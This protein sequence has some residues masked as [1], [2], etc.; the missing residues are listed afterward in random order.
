MTDS[1]RKGIGMFTYVCSVKT[2][3]IYQYVNINHFNNGFAKNLIFFYFYS[4]IE[5]PH[6]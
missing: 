6:V 1:F 3:S 5:I 4:L 2:V